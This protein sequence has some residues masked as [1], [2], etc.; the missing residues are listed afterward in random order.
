M[1]RFF[2]DFPLHVL[3]RPYLPLPEQMPGFQRIELLLYQRLQVL[4]DIG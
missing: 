1:W 2:M 4:R 3:S